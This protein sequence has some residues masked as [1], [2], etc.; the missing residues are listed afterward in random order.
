[1]AW[2]AQEKSVRVNHTSTVWVRPSEAGMT[3]N[4]ISTAKPTVALSQRMA[5]ATVPNMASGTS[6]P[7]FSRFHPL[8]AT[9]IRTHQIHDPA[10]TGK[11]LE[12]TNG[13]LS[14]PGVSPFE[15]SHYLMTRTFVRSIVIA[16]AKTRMNP[17]TICC[18]KTDTPMKVMPMRTT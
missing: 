7:G 2:S 9:I 3:T 16:T 13:E 15:L 14:P 6:R 8:I 12:M 17:N 4:M 1:M 11:L 18:A 5:L 10:T